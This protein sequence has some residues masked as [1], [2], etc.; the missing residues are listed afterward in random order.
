M[1]CV[2]PLVPRPV[3]Q[4]RPTGPGESRAVASMAA[5]PKGGKVG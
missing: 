2:E 5:V 1:G 3:K 4:I